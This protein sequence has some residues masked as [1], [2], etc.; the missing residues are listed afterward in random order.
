MPQADWYQDPSTPAQWRYWDGEAWTSHVAPAH[1]AAPPPA[2]AP[3]KVGASPSDPVHWLVP[4]GRSGE[5]I[6]AGYLGFFCLFLAIFGIAPWAGFF[7]LPIVGLTLWLAI[8]ALRKAST[9]G[10]GRGRAVFGIVGASI[11]GLSALFSLTLTV[12]LF[13]G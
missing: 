5:S 10:H 7:I 13:A 1:A 6:T 9:G 4:T 12:M 2:V 3:A 11:A 8:R